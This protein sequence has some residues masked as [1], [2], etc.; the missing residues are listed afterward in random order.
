[1]YRDI[2]QFQFQTGSLILF[3]IRLDSLSFATRGVRPKALARLMIFLFVLSLG[4]SAVVKLNFFEGKR[5]AH[6][7]H[8][9][10]ACYPG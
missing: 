8:L 9:A 10:T 2:V 4:A 5:L 3:Y 6:D 1:M 7:F